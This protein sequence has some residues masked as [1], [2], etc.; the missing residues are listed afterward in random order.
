M[1]NSVL[2]IRFSSFLLVI[3]LGLLLLTY[4]GDFII[5]LPFLWLIPILMLVPW[6]Y[7]FLCLY[8]LPKV[9]VTFGQRFILGFPVW[10]SVITIS[11]LI[12]FAPMVF[13]HLQDM[14]ITPEGHP[15]YHV[16]WLKKNGHFYKILNKGMP[17][18]I[19]LIEYQ[20]FERQK[21]GFIAFLV[22]FFSY[23]TLIMW[24]YI[25]CRVGTV[26]LSP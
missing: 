17:V 15:A 5:E 18:E 13:S 10:L 4:V 22:A 23:V 12:F 9:D 3:S 19:S 20:K 16:T 24:H 8:G 2:F 6:F 21:N 25:R 1:K 14:P 26:K 11:M 7:G